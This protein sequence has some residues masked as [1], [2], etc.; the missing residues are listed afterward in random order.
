MSER[1]DYVDFLHDILD[2]AHAILEFSAG[3]EFHQFARDKKTVYA[4]I[5]ALEIIGEA[6]KRIPESLRERH[7]DMPWRLMA[8]T[9]DK[10]IHDYS[11]VRL[12]TIWETVERDIPELETRLLEVIAAEERRAAGK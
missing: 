7:P 12:Q 3:M 8:G 1:R 4:V 10:V 11:G 6:T 9:R 2:A 5:R